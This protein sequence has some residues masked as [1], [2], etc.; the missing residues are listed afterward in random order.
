VLAQE[1]DPTMLYQVLRGLT[2]ASLSTDSWLAAA[3]FQETSGVVTDAAL[4]GKARAEASQ[5]HLIP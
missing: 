5:H 3:A 2:R 1:G 4:A